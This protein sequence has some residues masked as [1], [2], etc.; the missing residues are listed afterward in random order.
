MNHVGYQ[1]SPEYGPIDRIV[2]DHIL[3]IRL[4]DNDWRLTAMMLS[5]LLCTVIWP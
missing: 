5:V 1:P 2:A 4:S 3:L